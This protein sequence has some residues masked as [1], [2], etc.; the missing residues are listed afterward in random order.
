[1]EAT[2]M[3]PYFSLLLSYPHHDRRLVS[4]DDQRPPPEKNG[5][6]LRNSFGYQQ[7]RI[8]FLLLCI[9]SSFSL[10]CS[11]GKEKQTAETIAH[12]LLALILSIVPFLCVCSILP[13]TFYASMD[14]PFFFLESFLF[15]LFS[16]LLSIVL[17][18]IN[19]VNSF[20]LQCVFF[21]L[22][23]VIFECVEFYM[24]AVRLPCL[25][26]EIFLK[27]SPLR[28][29]F[30]HKAARA[31]ATQYSP[32]CEI[33]TFTISPCTLTN[34]RASFAFSI[35]NF[36]ALSVAVEVSVSRA[37]CFLRVLGVGDGEGENGEV[38]VLE[39][40]SAAV[41]ASRSKMPS[42]E[43]ILEGGCVCCCCSNGWAADRCC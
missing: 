8:P 11:C 36:S 34:S 14:S 10:C 37:G 3:I 42:S 41:T 9:L 24:R 33:D 26:L 16:R 27:L 6:D 13:V 22:A 15:P 2:N 23:I 30:T 38:E 17:Y 25:Y 1:M 29:L 5:Q 28:V 43:R 4:L 35:C 12:C 19:L 20:S 21:V 7:K 39:G 18:Q 32:S 31:V 40:F